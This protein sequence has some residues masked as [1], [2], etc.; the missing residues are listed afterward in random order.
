MLNLFVAA[1]T[2]PTI[3]PGGVLP[4]IQLTPEKTVMIASDLRGSV[5]QRPPDATV[6]PN[7]QSPFA[8]AGTSL[9]QNE[10]R[11]PPEQQTREVIAMAA[12]EDRDDWEEDDIVDEPDD[13]SEDSYY[14]ATYRKR[15]RSSAKAFD[16]HSKVVLYET[17]F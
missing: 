13:D 15:K 1:T 10:A 16:D 12:E 3:L 14:E 7:L 17:A 11:P 2:I 6:D 9:Q 8:A 4:S 5:S